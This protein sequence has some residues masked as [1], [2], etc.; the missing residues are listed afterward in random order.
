[1]NEPDTSRDI[2]QALWPERNAVIIARIPAPVPEPD[3]EPEPE[4]GS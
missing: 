1:M 4:A 2:P 3:P